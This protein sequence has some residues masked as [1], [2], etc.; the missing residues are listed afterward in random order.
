MHKL[1][2]VFLLFTSLSLLAEEPARDD[3]AGG[4]TVNTDDSA[5]IY[6]VPIPEKIYQ[7]VTRN[8]LGDIRV[9]N[10]SNE[11]VPHAIRKQKISRK[12]NTVKTELPFFPLLGEVQQQDITLGDDGSI[13]KIIFKDGNIE[14]IIFNVKDFPVENGDINQY[15]VDLGAIRQQ[16]DALEFE[17]T[18]ASATYIRHATIEVS[19]DLNS[20]SPLVTNAALSKLDYGGHTS[21]KARYL[22][23]SWREPADGIQ[24]KTIRATLLQSVTTSAQKTWTTVT[25]QRDAKDRSIYDFDSGGVYPIE[26]VEIIL[27]DPNTLIQATL[28]SRNDEKANWSR[29]TGGLFYNLNIKNTDIVRGPV[30]IAQ[31]KDRYWRLLVKTEDGIGSKMPQL[32]FAWY[33]N[34]IYFLARGQGP[35]TIAYGNA[36]VEAPGQPI[37]ALMRALSGKQQDELVKTAM[38]G[39]E[40]ALKG[41]AALQPDMNIPWQRILLWGVL[42]IGVLIIASMAI[43]LFR[44]MPGQQ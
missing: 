30:N 8:D 9:F 19:Q 17:M 5:A 25:G 42:V 44:Q 12:L 39:K 41:E 29:R 15:L 6:R 27:P 23:F 40:I 26:Q 1:L 28:K 7:T 16:V 20:W 37:D 10:A 36:N 31:T 4:F 34:E 14:K 35:F 2:T 3:F 22:R 43:R 24:I 32:R 13:Q 11:I 21:S 18:D 33:P 38:A